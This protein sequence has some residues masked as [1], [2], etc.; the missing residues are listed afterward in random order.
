VASQCFDQLI[1][2]V[3]IIGNFV[4]LVAAVAE[5]LEYVPKFGPPPHIHSREEEGFY[6]LE[7]EI[8]FSFGEERLVASAGNVCGFVGGTP[9]LQERDE[10]ASQ[11]AGLSSSRF[12]ADV[13]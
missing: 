11:V 4:Q 5:S 12:G 2:K 3:E 13:L 9:F 7:G 8:T 6:I 1:G 10:S